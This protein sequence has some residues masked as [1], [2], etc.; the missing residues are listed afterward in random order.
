MDEAEFKKYLPTMLKEISEDPQVV[1]LLEQGYYLYREGKG[2]YV[3][4]KYGTKHDAPKAIEKYVRARVILENLFMDWF[5]LESVNDKF[6]EIDW[7]I[8]QEYYS[9][10][11]VKK[12]FKSIAQKF[13]TEDTSFSDKEL[14]K[15]F[16]LFNEIIVNDP[17]TSNTLYSH[18]D[19]EEKRIIEEYKN[20]IGDR[21]SIGSRVH[22]YI[23]SLKKSTP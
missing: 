21:N 5:P 1:L 15:I 19:E 7:A 20:N 23:E 13:L 2:N 18:T 11:K 6:L 10:M 16:S 17:I 9:T 8:E 14:K 3:E 22:Q 4:L 12:D